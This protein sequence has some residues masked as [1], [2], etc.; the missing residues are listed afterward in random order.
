MS[1]VGGIKVASALE[2][3]LK[4]GLEVPAG[5]ATWAARG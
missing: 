3:T 1:G 5:A 4:E 2:A